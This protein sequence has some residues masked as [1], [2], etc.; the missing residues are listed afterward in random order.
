MRIGV[1]LN[2]QLFTVQIV[3][4]VLI[5]LLPDY[6]CEV[7]GKGRTIHINNFLTNTIGRLKLNEEETDNLIP[8]ESHII[9]NPGK[10]LID[11]GILI[12]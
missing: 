1:E 9:I 4:S 8:S 12:N 2:A 7:T 3:E 6:S 5:K 11:G 10:N